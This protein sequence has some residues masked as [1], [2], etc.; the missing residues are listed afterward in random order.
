LELEGEEVGVKQNIERKDV[1]YEDNRKEVPGRL[2]LNDLLKR[3]KEASIREKKN[4][5][6]LLTYVCGLA[7]IVIVFIAFY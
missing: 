2:D 7:A 6:I 4:N 5:A 3:K 1:Y